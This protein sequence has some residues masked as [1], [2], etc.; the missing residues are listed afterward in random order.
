MSAFASAIDA[1]FAD[2]NIARDA[3]YTPAAGIPFPV[4]V[5]ARRGDLVSEFAER[6]VAAA[7][8]VLDLRLSEVPD[9]RAGDRI[10]LGGEVLAV[11]GAPI[12]D[13]ERLIWTLDTRP[14]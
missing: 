9:P 10:E 3:I 4:R 11:Q 12:R 7:T 2:P 14:A 6:R 13:S 5:I 8:V 1:L